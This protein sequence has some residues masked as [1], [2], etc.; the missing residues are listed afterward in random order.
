MKIGISS[1]LLG[2]CC[3]YNGGSNYNQEL[4]DLINDH[5]VIAIC[6]EV[7]GGLPTP[8]V[9]AEIVNGKVINEKGV[10][11]TDCYNLGALEALKILKENNVEVVILKSKSPSCGHGLIYDGTFSHTVI[12]GDGVSAKLFMENGI[13]VYS[14]DNYKDLFK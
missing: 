5:E 3:K 2:Y 8:R 1:C 7:L 4:I 9:P 11:V 13:K 12:N 10:D 6:P 14:E